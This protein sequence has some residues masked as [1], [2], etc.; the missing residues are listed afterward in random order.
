ML[1]ETIA[2]PLY[3]QLKEKLKNEIAEGRLKPGEKLLPEVELAQKYE[4]S[5]ITVRRA[6]NELRNEGLLEKRQ[7]KGTFVA[8]AKYPKDL[9]QILSFTEASKLI[10]AVPSAKVLASELMIPGNDIL[11]Q[12][13]L[14]RAVKPFISLVSGCWITIRWLSKTTIFPFNIRF[15]WKR[16]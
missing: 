16:T 9:N 10:G 4:V 11:E 15:C 3:E 2:T 13:E 14:P 6:T 7:G 8:M 1:D 5:V 12:L